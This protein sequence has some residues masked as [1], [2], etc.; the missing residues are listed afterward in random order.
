MAKRTSG[1]T[2][3]Q[4]QYF[5]E[6]AAEGS[7]TAAADILFVAQP[8]MSAAMK[9]LEHRVG[10]DLLTRSARGVTLTVDGVEFLGY[11]RQVVEQAELLEQRY[12]G[13]PPSR[14]LLG[15][16]TQHYSFA[17]DAFVRMVKGTNAAEYEFS[18]RETRTFD[19]IEDVRT[20]RSELGI[21]FRND[22]NRNVLDKL[23]RD[24][25]L[26]F[27]PLF[28]AEPH[29]FVSRRNPLA[30][31][32]RATLD[33]LVALPRLTFDQGANN[34]FY[35]AEEILSTLSSAQEIRV[36]DRA[37]IFNLMIGLDGYTISTGIISDDLDPEIVAVPLDVDEHIEIG[38]IGRTAIPLTEQ[39]QRYLAEVRDVVAGF[40]VEVLG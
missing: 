35:F 16:S 26:A 1:I 34:S 9:D 13:R 20:L 39:A 18:L 10:R 37:T 27:H 33:D 32:T 12:L 38:W 29:I 40:G 21:L 31:R 36:S 28:V 17:V 14:R 19:I 24:S 4:L 30:R 7:I 5:I 6:V 22:F 25:G 2:L 15:V 3:Q 23:L 11:A 8:T